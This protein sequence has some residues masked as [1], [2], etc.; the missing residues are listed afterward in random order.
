MIV[1]VALLLGAVQTAE[2]TEK[3]TETL[4]A[5]C[6]AHRFETTVQVT[7]ADGTPHPSKVKLCGKPGQS[8]ADWARTLKD[9]AGKV[10]A[11]PKMRPGVKAQIIG[12]L[13]AEIAKLPA[14]GEA[15]PEPSPSIVLPIAP[16]PAARPTPVV[17]RVASAPLIGPSVGG[18]VEYSVLPPLP[19]PQPAASAAATGAS[20]PPL[21]AP[22]MTFRCMTTTSL[23]AE[24]PCDLLER[25]TLLT[26]RADEDLPGG[27]SLRFLRRGDDRAEVELAQLKRGQAQRFALPTRVCQGVAG[28]RVEIQIVR[29][30]KGAPQVVDTRGPFELRC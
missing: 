29:A 25:N 9:A 26:V 22:R 3:A 14:V 27:T 15:K 18:P 13:E 6:L 24:G 19:A 30:A 10:A 20:I 2:T 8:D 4:A 23:S 7:G 21:P 11:D 16:P 28:S 5:A 1:L 12:A 17:G